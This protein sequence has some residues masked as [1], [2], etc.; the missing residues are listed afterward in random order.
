MRSITRLSGVLAAAGLAAG[1]TLAGTGPASAAGCAGWS[2]GQPGGGINLT[3]VAVVS[4]CDVWAAGEGG[5]GVSTL[6]E[7]WTGAS[8][9]VVPAPAPG[10][11]S[12]IFGLAVVSAT[13]I[14]AVGGFDTADSQR[15]GLILHWDGSAWTQQQFQDPGA[16]LS[17]VTAVSASDA[18]AVG[19]VVVGPAGQGTD[20]VIL[21][22]N[23]SAWTRVPSPNPGTNTSGPFSNYLA[24]VTATSPSSA[25]AVGGFRGSNAG[26]SM[27]LHWDGTSWTQ[28]STPPGPLPVR[29]S[30]R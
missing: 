13:D 4:E 27:L 3:A 20:T 24:R 7:H 23:G 11:D 18:W 6:I 17:A 8:W 9:S 5:S 10:A 2:G 26:G 16:T 12:F 25:W 28:Q 30:P 15:H 14:W 1:L 19:T 21:H 29:T 22:W